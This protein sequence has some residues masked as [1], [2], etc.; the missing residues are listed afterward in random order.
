LAEADLLFFGRRVNGDGDV[1]QAK[2]DATLP[3]RTHSER[4]YSQAWRNVNRRS[5]LENVGIISQSAF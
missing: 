2:A 5:V 1:N 4:S 3:N